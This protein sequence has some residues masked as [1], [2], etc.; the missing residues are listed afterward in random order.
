MQAQSYPPW[1]IPI[2][3]RLRDE[4]PMENQI[5]HW[6]EMRGLS[7]RALAEKIG[8]GETQILKLENGERRLTQDWMERL[9]RGLDCSPVDLIA[10]RGEAAI[11]KPDK[12]VA[13]RKDT[14]AMEYRGSQYLL[15]PQFDI[16]VSAG[17]GAINDEREEPFGFQPF[18]H[19]WI[20]SLTRTPPNSLAIVRVDGDSMWETLHNGDHV[21][22]DRAKASVG[23]D[24]IYVLR[25][26][27]DLLVKRLQV[28]L[29]THQVTVISDNPKYPTY[30][31]DP[32]TIAV[33]GRV[34]W[35]GRSV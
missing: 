18:E 4:S 20:R 2:R 35:V 5:R 31:V 17:P 14:E 16:R 10:K 33:I 13:P 23:R 6:R 30:E 3:A 27:Q 25:Y 9:S 28:N 11:A 21:L 29:Q 12:P 19:N 8:T 1:A 15:L 7:R 22:I 24:G 26:D 32:G 34:I